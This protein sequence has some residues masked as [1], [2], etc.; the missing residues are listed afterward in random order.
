MIL[1]ITIASK[2][3]VRKCYSSQIRSQNWFF[4]HGNI[5]LWATDFIPFFNIFEA[6]NLYNVQI[7][8]IEV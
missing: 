8:T 6:N 1:E 5:I 2:G 7:Y 3:K 4:L